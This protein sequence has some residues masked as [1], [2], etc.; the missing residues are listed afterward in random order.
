[1]DRV[2]LPVKSLAILLHIITA[3]QAGK[4]SLLSQWCT[5]L[6]KYRLIDMLTVFT[7]PSVKE[8]IVPTFMN[9]NSLLRIVIAT[10]VLWGEGPP[11]DID[12]Y[13]QDT[14]RAGRDGAQATA[15]L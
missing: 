6:E 3:Q 14:G 11:S 12:S 10:V 7:H 2:L 15:L 8:N 1:M 13:L 5:Y 4:G 9:A